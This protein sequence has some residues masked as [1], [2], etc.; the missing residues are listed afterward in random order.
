MN[1][2][3]GWMII[4]RKRQEIEFKVLNLRVNKTTEIHNE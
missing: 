2:I 3:G 4:Q 1:G